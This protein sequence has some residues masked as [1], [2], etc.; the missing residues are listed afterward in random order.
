M[1]ITRALIAMLAV[2][3]LSLTTGCGG[4]ATDATVAS[5]TASSSAK[6]AD[7]KKAEKA[8][9]TMTKSQEQAVKKAESYLATGAF[10]K[11]GLTEQLKFEG[12]PAKDAEFAVENIEVDWKDQAAKKAESYL[13]TGS[14]SRTGLIEQLEFEGFTEAQAKHGAKS[15]G[16]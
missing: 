1:K 16:L 3:I 12:F 13:E 8:K 5:D 11:K 14:F 6:K 7:K 10:S 15:V 2:A 4:I 9:P